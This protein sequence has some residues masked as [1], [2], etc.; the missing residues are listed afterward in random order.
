MKNNERQLTTEHTR[1]NQTGSIHTRDPHPAAAEPQPTAKAQAEQA[2]PPPSSKRKRSWKPAVYALGGVGFVALV[3]WAFWPSP[4][5]VDMAVVERGLLQVTVE[6]E[7]KTR[8]RERFEIAAPVDG[9]LERISVRVGDPVSSGDVIARIDPLP[10]ASQVQSIQAQIQRLE[11]EKRGVDTQRPKAAS[12]V[13]AEASIAAAQARYQQTLAQ[14]AEAQATWEQAQRERQRIEDLFGQGAIPRQA[15]EEAELAVTNRGQI[16]TVRQLEVEQAQAAVLSAQQ[17]LQLLQAQQRDP[18]YL[19]Q[20]YDAQIRSLE[21]E[22][23][24]LAD[25]AQRTTLT[26]PSAGQVLRVHQEST[27]FVP[28]G[29]VLVEVGDPGQLEL[30]MDVL[31]SD[32][33]RIQPGDPV[34]IRQW[35]GAEVL[36]GSVRTVEPAAFTKVSALGVEEQR[37]NIIA[38]IE[39]PPARLGDGYRIEAE[40]IIWQNEEALKLPLSALFRCQEEWCVYVAEEGRAQ[41]RQVALGQRSTTAAEVLEGLEAGETVILYPSDQVQPGRRIQPR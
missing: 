30:E 24:S 31:S 26:S 41:A 36:Q 8:L 6:T 22:L 21:A 38:N 28:A 11:A 14:Q 20:V 33:V 19:L 39:D 35:G 15:L 29:T 3:G 4:V 32:A 17:G 1:S 25:S 5:P 16:L 12:L 18:D 9:R 34:Q 37:V 2:S 40:V 10:L 13:Q 23:A 7:G 27:R